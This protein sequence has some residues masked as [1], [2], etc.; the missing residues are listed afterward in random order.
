LLM[1]IIYNSLSPTS[2]LIPILYLS[3]FLLVLAGIYLNRDLPGRK[4]M[5]LGVSLNLLVIVLNGF[6]MPV[7]ENL[8]LWT[9]EEEFFASS[10]ALTHSIMEPGTRLKLL[11][12]IFI[13][14][15]G[16]FGSGIYSLGDFLLYIGVVQAISSKMI[17]EQR[18]D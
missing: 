5:L 9:T 3:S 17:S 15:P 6:K 13:I 7:T 11:S 14:P 1:L 12:D 8:L 16:F 2:H 10:Q 18:L 4:L